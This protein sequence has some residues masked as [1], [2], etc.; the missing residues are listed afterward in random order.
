MRPGSA[1]STPSSCPSANGSWPPSRQQ[2]GHSRRSARSRR[3]LLG[4]GIAATLAATLAANVA[5]GLGHGL[6][7]GAV[8]A[9][10]EVALVGSYEFSPGVLSPLHDV[11]VKRFTKSFCN[12]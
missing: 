8:A 6:V 3:W 5:R 12:T 11:A 1:T 9:W 4:L 2:T 7:G 10:P